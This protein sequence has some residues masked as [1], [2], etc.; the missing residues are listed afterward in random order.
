MLRFARFARFSLYAKRMPRFPCASAANDYYYDYENDGE[1]EAQPVDQPATRPVDDPRANSECDDTVEA[2]TDEEA[3]PPDLPRPGTNTKM[4]GDVAR[5]CGFA[6][7][8]PRESS[9]V[10]P[11][12]FAP[13]PTHPI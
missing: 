12:S 5:T 13:R 6:S 10:A 2:K 9:M 8:I 11:I 1:L 7:E 4:A 3:Q